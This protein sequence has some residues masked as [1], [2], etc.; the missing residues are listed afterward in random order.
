VTELSEHRW[1]PP[2]SIARPTAGRQ[3]HPV[4]SWW[5]WAQIG[6]REVRMGSDRPLFLMLGLTAEDEADF[7]AGS[8]PAPVV[9]ELNALPWQRE[10]AP[11]F[12]LVAT[13]EAIYVIH[14]APA[15]AA[16]N[17]A[18]LMRRL[19]AD[20]PDA[21]VDGVVQVV[22]WTFF[23]ENAAN[24][25]D[26]ADRRLHRLMN[27]T[28]EAVTIQANLR[29]VREELL[30]HLPLIVVIAGMKALPGFVELN[31]HA[32]HAAPAGGGAENS[33]PSADAGPIRLEAPASA[34]TPAL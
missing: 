30:A 33:S 29:V 28:R 31:E 19:R 16:E 18:R 1:F 32:P 2:R 5:E 4:D 11:P 22:P 9:L 21:P 15:G 26:N 6:L 14:D 23:V 12:R 27:V 3:S 17:L 7:L 10:E 8:E 34:T 24:E 25:I 20:R 13:T